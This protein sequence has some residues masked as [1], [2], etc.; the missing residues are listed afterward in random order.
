MVFFI[1]A[2]GETGGNSVLSKDGLFSA[3]PYPCISR[4]LPGISDRED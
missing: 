1:K 4:F 3:A 2:K